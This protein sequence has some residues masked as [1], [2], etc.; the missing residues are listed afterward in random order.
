MKKTGWKGITAI[1][2]TLLLCM[3]LLSAAFAMVVSLQTD[4]QGGYYYNMPN[5]GNLL[6]LNLTD[7]TDGFTFKVYD[8]GGAD[9]NYSDNCNNALVI[10]A[11][12]DFVLT[13]SGTGLTEGVSFDNV[14]IYDGDTTTRLGR[15]GGR[16]TMPELTTSANVM[17]ICFY[18]D[19]RTNADG[20]ELTVTLVDLSYYAHVRYAYG[21]TVKTF[22]LEEG[23]ATQLKTFSSLFTLPERKLFSCWEYGGNS[24]NEGDT[25][26][27]SGDKT[28]TA[29]LEDEPAVL[30]DG[31]G[32]YYSKV[33]RTGT[34]T[35]DLSDKGKGFS[36]KVYDH[37]GKDARY[38]YGCNGTLLIQAPAGYVLS[39]T[40]SGSTEK[41][42]D[43]LE[44]YDGDT[45]TRLGPKYEGSFTMNDYYTSGNVLKVYFYSQYGDRYDGFD[46][47]VAVV[48][49][50]DFAEISF[51]AGEGSGAMDSLHALPGSHIP[52]PECGFT[53]PEK[54]F[55]DYYTDG[56]NTYR[57]GDVYTVSGNAVLTAVYVEK[58]AV[59]YQS[60]ENSIVDYYPKGTALNLPNYADKFTLAYRTECAGWRSGGHDYAQGEAY[61]VTGDVTMTAIVNAL[62]IMI[63]DGSGGYSCDMPEKEHVQADLSGRPNGFTFTLYDNGGKSRG[64]SHNCDGSLTFTAPQGYIFMISGEGATE[65]R[66]DL[67][68][69]YDSDM[70]ALLGASPYSGNFT[71]DG[72]FTASNALKV[73]FTSDSSSAYKGFAL[74]VTV[75]DPATLITV[76]FDPGEG[77][78][79]MD[80][81]T[82]LSGV[83]FTLP[84]YGFTTPEGKIFAGYSDGTNTYWPGGS[85]AFSTNT[86]LTALWVN[87][88]GITYSYGENMQAVRYPRGEAITVPEFSAIFGQLPAGRFVGW[89]EKFTGD[90]YQPGDEYVPEDPTVF[91]ALIEFLSSDGSGGWYAVMPASTY[92]SVT[93]DLSDRA[94]GFSFTLYDNGGQNGYYINGCN[95]AITIKAPENTVLQVRGS[96][97]TE[98]GYD[99]LK[100]YDGAS[101]T[102][103]ALGSEK[104]TGYFA[105]NEVLE[106]EGNYLTVYFYSD[107]SQTASGFALTVTLYAQTAVSY[108]FDGETKTVP[109]QMDV[110]ITLAR[111][112]DLFDSYDREFVCWQ[113]GE[114]TYDAGEEFLVTG[115]VTFT[116]VTR[117]M[118]TITFDGSGTALIDGEEG[119]TVSPAI[120]FPTGDTGPL[121]HASLLFV[122]PEN[123]CFG[124]WV[125]NGRTWT[126]GEEFTLTED[127]VLTA[128]WRDANAWDRLNDALQ[129]SSGTD[130][131]TLTLTEDAAAAMGSLPLTIPAGVTVTIDLNGHALSGAQAAVLDGDMITVFG[132]LTIKGSGAF[133]GGNVT[134]YE[135][136]SFT[137]GGAAGGS[138]AAAATKSYYDD[139]D[140]LTVYSV[141][142]CPTM[143][144]VLR[145]AAYDY[146][147]RNAI[148]LLKNVTV[149]QGETLTILSDDGLTL[150][151]NGHTLNV[152]GTL[153]RRSSEAYILIESGMPGVFRSSGTVSVDLIAWTQDAYYFTGGMVSGMF[154]ADGGSIHISGGHFTD[155]VMFNNGNREAELEITLSGS[156]VLDELEQMI[157]A[158]EGNPSIHMTISDEVRVGDML[159]AIVDDGTLT[160]PALT[161][162]GGYFTTDP[163][164]WR[165]EAQVDETVLEI[166]CEPEQYDGQTDWAADGAVY[167]WRVKQ[168]AQGPALVLPSALTQIGE[169]AFENCGASEVYVPS[170]CTA[171]GPNAF[172]DCK[173]LRVIHIPAS[174][175]AIDGTAFDGCGAELYISGEKGSAAENFCATHSPIFHEEGTA[176]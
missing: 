73:L 111:F 163:R 3:G 49:P 44:I 48:D 143:A 51:D 41:S 116:A 171:I 54:T 138:F 59:T 173:N 157:Y 43:Y 101:F 34:V 47:N 89:Q 91:N 97:Q 125:C 78:G 71:V 141:S 35:A 166:A 134:V 40:G 58:C 46:L 115:G 31:A 135:D 151:L 105:I 57:G 53:L 86:T 110:P 23:T 61:T 153:T 130:L 32:G 102:A 68:S 107:S 67:L 132:S 24:Y 84:D 121:P 161:V 75:L 96:G 85:A 20:Y 144:S 21:E 98:N 76:S 37:A 72:L 133:S 9:G 25:I 127:T 28:F 95:G 64:Y 123:K 5:L 146:E 90:I 103:N 169:S 131:G 164:V 140:S 11:P 114:D 14:T 74:D 94:S 55:F 56:T 156:A 45:S 112:E 33:P 128:V 154:A 119:Q 70:T 26:T 167:P 100:L 172:K 88:T 66:Y 27:A 118:P 168:A 8:E 15:Y 13:V 142:Y 80:P 99:Y 60:G 69:I 38:K 87:V 139:D 147:Y 17:K 93:M 92:G 22:L 79:A 16:F 2:L 39:V 108:V 113:N 155:T 18:S 83:A 174:V 29:V 160:Y 175:T 148:T 159:F 4:S 19:S 6:E 162:S 52:L 136:G 126:A 62:P 65:N 158:V 30:S 10:T 117:L 36:L 1:L 81:L 170:G 42:Y 152:K 149:A 106:T 129:A 120:P 124:G 50:A 145:V 165:E 12:E 150:N 82:A 104:Y 122:T 63:D 176:W 77:S 109:V 7:K 137:P